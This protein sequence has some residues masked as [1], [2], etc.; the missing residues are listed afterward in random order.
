MVS[1]D[2]FVVF[3]LFVFT[4]PSVLASA[5]TFWWTASRGVH[6]LSLR[7]LIWTV[8][9]IAI[10]LGAAA[11]DLTPIAK[12]KDLEVLDLVQTNLTTNR[13]TDLAY[14][15]IPAI[16]SALPNCCIFHHFWGAFDKL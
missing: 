3:G 1:L 11:P 7:A 6:G 4:A 14:T 5:T 10:L 8:T 2:E 16:R 15:Q 9:V 12:L 13:G